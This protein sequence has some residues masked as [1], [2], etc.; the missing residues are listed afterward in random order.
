MTAELL[1]SVA[2]IALV[3]VVAAFL[4][5]CYVGCRM[6]RPKGD[7]EFEA[8]MAAP[9]RCPVTNSLACPCGCR[10]GFQ[11]TCARPK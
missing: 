4:G 7:D 10:E 5:G 3:A 6:E 2:I 8:V 1:K 11:C 9:V